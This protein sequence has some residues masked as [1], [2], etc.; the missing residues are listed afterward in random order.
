MHM[1]RRMRT[2]YYRSRAETAQWRLNTAKLYEQ[3]ARDAQR[4]ITLDPVDWTPPN[5][6]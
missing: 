6:G 5:A 4:Y 2:H 1:P 3:Y